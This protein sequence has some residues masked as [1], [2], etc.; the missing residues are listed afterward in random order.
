[1][2]WASIDS[3]TVSGIPPFSKVPLKKGGAALAA[4]VVSE[5]TVNNHDLLAY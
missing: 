1:M 2:P 4:G 5:V 3:Q